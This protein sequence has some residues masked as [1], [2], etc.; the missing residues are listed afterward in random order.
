MLLPFSVAAKDETRTFDKPA[1]QV[2]EAALNVA[3]EQDVVIYSDKDHLTLTFKSGG[4]WNK[5]FEVAVQVEKVE[6][7]KTRVTLKAQKTYFGAGWGAAARIEKKFFDG[8]EE[9]L[10]KKRPGS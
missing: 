3:K 10:E 4:Y 6:P 5:G 2:F 8:L 1:N 7:V 9:E